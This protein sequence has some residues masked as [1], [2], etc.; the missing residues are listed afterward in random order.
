MI[1]FVYKVVYKRYKTDA[2]FMII[3][4]DIGITSMARGCE[5]IS[6]L[7]SSDFFSILVYQA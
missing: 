3:E 2:V 6:I 1:V 4:D 7:P 5:A